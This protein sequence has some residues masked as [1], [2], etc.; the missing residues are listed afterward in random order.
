MLCKIMRQKVIGIVLLIVGFYLVLINPVL[1]I[2]IHGVFNLRIVIPANPFTAWI[3]ILELLWL[4]I[5]I[6]VAGVGVIFVKYGRRNV[7]ASQA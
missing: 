4:W 5:T 6:L 7:L 3:H 1:S 2:L